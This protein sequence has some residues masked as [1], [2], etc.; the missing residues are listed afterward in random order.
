MQYAIIK[1]EV[2][3]MTM[4]VAADPKMD[5]PH[6][7]APIADSPKGRVI[8]NEPPENGERV[9]GHWLLGLN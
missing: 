6:V 4:T 2:V 3:G 7:N 9:V 5:S 1:L 8:I